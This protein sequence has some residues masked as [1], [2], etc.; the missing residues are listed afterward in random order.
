LPGLG[1]SGAFGL[2][3][4]PAGQ[5]LT[6]SD[7]GHHR[8][9]KF[10]RLGGV[11]LTYT[12]SPQLNQV[13][14]LALDSSGN[15]YAADRNA[16]EILELGLP[17]GAGF[18]MAARSQTTITP[19]SASQNITAAGGG[20]IRRRGGQGIV[21]PPGALLQDTK[22][23]VAD[24]IMR[25][26]YEEAAKAR[27]IAEHGLVAVSSQVAYS[28]DGTI[29]QVPATLVIP[30]DASQVVANGLSELGL[31]VFYWNPDKQYWQWIPSTVDTVHHTVSG[32]VMHFSVYQALGR[33][34]KQAPGST[35]H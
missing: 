22:I 5:C 30:Y 17:A 6:V 12:G 26:V 4:D 20:T 24:W 29:F 1:L 23:T 14:G 3:V 28:P 35:S 32:Q 8:V 21:I 18:A 25:S 19:T 33:P 9:V 7:S 15:L 2:A 27:K 16:G 11:N 10:D 31:Q 13:Q 34:M